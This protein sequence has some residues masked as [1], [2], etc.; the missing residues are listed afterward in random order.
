MNH[1]T[2]HAGSETKPGARSARLRRPTG[3][4]IP[5]W[6]SIRRQNSS[7]CWQCGR[8]IGGWWWRCVPS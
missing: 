3:H 7:S 1:S 4:W 8:H 6:R 5:S 2:A